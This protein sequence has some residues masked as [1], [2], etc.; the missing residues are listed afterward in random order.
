[1][2]YHLLSLIYDIISLFVFPH[3]D[4]RLSF[5]YHFTQSQHQ[6]Q[7]FNVEKKSLNEILEH[8][9]SQFEYQK[10]QSDKILQMHQKL[11]D[12]IEKQSAITIQR[13]I[14]EAKDKQII[15]SD[16]KQRK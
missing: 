3:N 5:F 14:I 16:L 8:Y 15:N 1:M 9:K 2:Y 4:D 10:T 11:I 12:T 13:N 7:I 6:E